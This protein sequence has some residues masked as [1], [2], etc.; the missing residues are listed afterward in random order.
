M[1]NMTM[2]AE[3]GNVMAVDTGL[4]EVLN[5]YRNNVSVY[6]TGRTDKKGVQK[7]GMAFYYEDLEGRRD[8]K[9][10]T[11]A[12]DE[13]L[14]N[15]RTAFLTDLYYQKKARK[16]VVAQVAATVQ[17]GQVVYQ[18]VYQQPMYMPVQ[19]DKTVSEAVDSF[20]EYYKPTVSYQTY[21][22]EISNA[23]NIKRY[24][25]HM[26]VANV[27]FS[28]FQSL[29]NTVSKGKNGK[30][31]A[32][33]TV[34]NIIISF[35]RIMRYCRK[36]RW[37]SSDE[38]DLIISD[39]KI[40]TFVTDT[41]HAE[42]V[43]K[44]KF[45]NYE[46]AGEV[47]RIL[48]SNR[49]YYLVARILFLT[50]MRPQE[51]FA[52][53]REDLVP[54]EDYIV[55]NKAL[56]IQERTKAGI[57]NYGMGTTKNRFSRRKVPAIPV[58]FKYFKELEKTLVMEGG[59]AKSL[60]KGNE[61]LV[62][63]DKNG[64]MVDIHSFGVNLDRFVRGLYRETKKS[65]RKFTLNMPRHCFQDYLAVLGAYDKDVEKAVGHVLPEVSERFYKIN[66][67]YI[68]DLLPFIQKMEDNIEKA[69]REAKNR[70]K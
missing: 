51:F 39:V 1:K 67:Q 58:V 54:E 11:G 10:V 68:E 62:M 46:Q 14:W 57:R 36:Q 6:P 64:N 61:N 25:G 9:V 60:E 56:V 35:R 59:R 65:D 27:D 7:R 29:V 18:P 2:V 55:V 12:A 34:R 69:Y 8:R 63:V 15:K 45:L 37:I 3:A 40:P 20:M 17:A 44:S 13:E 50:G 66:I 22:G 32:V 33:K 28:D 16:E 47:L 5:Q 43:K 48:E 21:L 24:L 23:N 31:A 4:V 19:C 30:P 70:E 38:L 41:D 26:R 42:L 52:L 49:R 53:E